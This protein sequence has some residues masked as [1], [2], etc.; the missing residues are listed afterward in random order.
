MVVTV[1]SLAEEGSCFLMKGRLMKISV[2]SLEK[3]LNIRKS[4][5]ILN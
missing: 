2:L 5:F 1:S 4:S 3:F